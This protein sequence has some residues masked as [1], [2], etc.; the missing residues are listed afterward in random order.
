[1]ELQRFFEDA[2]RRSLGDLARQDDPAAGYLADLLT[3]FARNLYQR[4]RFVPANSKTELFQR[5]AAADSQLEALF[6]STTRI[7]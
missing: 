6:A 4:L 5:Y 3:R 2:V 1:M 7:V